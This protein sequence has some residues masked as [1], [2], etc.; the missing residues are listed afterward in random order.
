MVVSVRRKATTHFSLMCLLLLSKAIKK[1]AHVVD[2]GLNP[3]TFFY[4]GFWFS[5][6]EFGS[7]EISHELWTCQIFYLNN[8]YLDFYPI[9]VSIVFAGITQRYRPFRRLDKENRCV[10]AFSQIIS[11]IEVCYVLFSIYCLTK[12]CF[13]IPLLSIKSFQGVF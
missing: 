10:F 4:E 9:N 2:K 12:L 1:S 7:L 5:F 3:I 8:F 13:A 6:R 11:T